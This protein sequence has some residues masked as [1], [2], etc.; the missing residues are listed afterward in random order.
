LRIDA[1]WS[2]AGSVEEHPD[3]S[4]L[5]QELAVGG[6]ED[7][8]ES[9]PPSGRRLPHPGHHLKLIAEVS[10]P[11]ILDLMPPHDPQQGRLGLRRSQRLPVGHGCVLHITQERN[12]VDMLEAV[13]I[14]RL[15][16]N[17]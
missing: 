9:V 11:K 7:F 14:S 6:A 15:N 12:V 8:S 10:R 3:S 5:H 17:S 16:P 13:D 4:S 1:A 2:A